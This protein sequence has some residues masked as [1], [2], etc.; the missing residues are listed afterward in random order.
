MKPYNPERI[1]H[2]FHVFYH[3]DIFGDRPMLTQKF[4]IEAKNAEQAKQLTL[5]KLNFLFGVG[6]VTVDKVV[7]VS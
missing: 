3:T 6:H 4:T 7:C 2:V 5:K 1:F